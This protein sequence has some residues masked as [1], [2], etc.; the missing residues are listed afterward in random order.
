MA[1]LILSLGAY[2]SA[3]GSFMEYNL[4]RGASLPKNGPIALENARLA[5]CRGHR[6]DGFGGET[7]GESKAVF[8][9][10]CLKIGRFHN[11]AI[12][13]AIDFSRDFAYDCQVAVWI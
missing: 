9:I 2:A 12:T 10:C 5:P 8:Q 6:G 1:K 7:R 4:R 3:P 13:H 11:F